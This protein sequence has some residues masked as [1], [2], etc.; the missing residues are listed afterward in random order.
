MANSTDKLMADEMGDSA[1]P[2]MDRMMKNAAAG[3]ESSLP[4]MDENVKDRTVTIIAI[5]SITVVGLLGLWLIVGAMRSSGS[6]DDGTAM[7]PKT[8]ASGQLMP[9]TDK[10]LPVSPPTPGT[11]PATPVAG[12]ADME[13]NEIKIT[14]QVAVDK[15]TQPQP[16]PGAL[17]AA[18]KTVIETGTPAATGS[19]T[20]DV[21][22]SEPL[23]KPKKPRP[24][25]QYGVQLGV[26]N[27]VANAESLRKKMQAQGVPVVI[28]SRVH[29]GPFATQ[30]EADKAREK[31]KTMGIEESAMVI[32]K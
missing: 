22:V 32:L 25:Q 26:F 2:V 1:N 27:S 6:T 15:V 31:L 12:M 4:V 19:K 13:S 10:S 5:I 16:A 20:V 17:P 8:V 24:V 28:E 21:L 23:I 7:V 29:I 18:K 11:L 9:R 3:E 30:A 14:G